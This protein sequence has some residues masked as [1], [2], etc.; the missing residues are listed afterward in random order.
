MLI[1]WSR[2]K[3]KNNDNNKTKKKVFPHLIGGLLCWFGKG[4]VIG[5]RW[6]GIMLAVF[7]P[8]FRADFAFQAADPAMGYVNRALMVNLSVQPTVEQVQLV[9]SPSKKGIT[10]DYRF[11][12]TNLTNIRRRSIIAS[13]VDVVRITNKVNFPS[14][15]RNETKCW[16]SSPKKSHN[17]CN[18]MRTKS[19]H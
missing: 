1:N 3:K 14:A 8:S 5:W 13:P 15:V 4:L 19:V 7:V 6:R 2:I 10:I 12:I 17:R 18:T 16:I 11:Q 9:Q